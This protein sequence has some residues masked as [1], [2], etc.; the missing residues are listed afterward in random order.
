MNMRVLN[1]NGEDDSDDAI[2]DRA[3]IEE[4]LEAFQAQSTVNWTVRVGRLPTANMRNGGKEAFLFNCDVQ[5]L[6]IDERLRDT[7]GTGQY[8]VRVQRAGKM[9]KM[10]DIAVEA[11]ATP[12]APPATDM[13]TLANMIEAANQRTMQMVEQ[14]LGRGA[15]PAAADPFAALER[16]TAIMANLQKAA[17]MAAPAPDHTAM[18]KQSI[19]LATLISGASSR[20]ETGFMDVLKELAGSEAVTGL[21]GNFMARA[22][23][24]TT[25]QSAAPMLAPAGSAYVAPPVAPAN[26]AGMDQGATNKLI[27][28]QI[29]FLISMA[30]AGRDPG[31]Y[32]EMMLD[33]M[34]PPAVNYILSN[35]NVI[36]EL[37]QY[38]AA[39]GQHVQ[40]FQKLLE[41]MRAMI[42]GDGGDETEPDNAATTRTA[43][44]N[45]NHSG[46]QGGNGGNASNY[47]GARSAV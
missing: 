25:P 5:D 21:F 40:W 45:P 2:A 6:P 10:F 34:P 23:G 17:P 1:G 15:A 13:A 38:N 24:Q 20:G 26:M 28:E 39:V 16:I 27:G 31:L 4:I 36:G 18:F 9:F 37:T 29:A 44:E 8:R 32:A 22:T 19:E 42:Q 46:R 11:P 30:A 35:P 43:G 33:N 7:Y 14:A 3:V 12:A 41:A 47:A